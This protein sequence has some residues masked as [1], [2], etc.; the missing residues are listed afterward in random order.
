MLNKIL[1]YVHM[2]K[3]MAVLKIS[4]FFDSFY[5]GNNM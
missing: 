1:L 4:N 3:S 2:K 5:K